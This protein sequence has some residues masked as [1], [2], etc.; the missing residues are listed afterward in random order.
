MV[1]VLL[2]L[3]ARL[4][5]ELR[6]KDYAQEGT[7][8]AMALALVA[9]AMLA[10][11]PLRARIHHLGFYQAAL[12][13][14]VAAAFMVANVPCWMKSGGLGRFVAAAGCVIALAVGCGEIAWQSQKIHADQTQASGRAGSGFTPTRRT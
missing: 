9:V 5:G 13:G 7:V 2:L 12:A 10:R 1:I 4:V 8:M 3:A 6:Q 14:M 11:M